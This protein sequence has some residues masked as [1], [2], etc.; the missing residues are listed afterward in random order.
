[1]QLPSSLTL[2]VLVLLTLAISSLG[3]LL[4]PVLVCESV[5][6]IGHLVLSASHLWLC[7]SAFSQHHLRTILVDPSPR[8][9]HLC[10]EVREAVCVLKANVTGV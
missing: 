3:H 10:C 5:L 1:M 8:L 4:S 2:P 6:D 7:N 9:R